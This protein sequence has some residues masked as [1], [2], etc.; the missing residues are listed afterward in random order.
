MSHGY[1]VPNVSPRS[2]ASPFRTR[3]TS[4]TPRFPSGDT[5]IGREAASPSTAAAR[6][7]VN[8]GERDRHGRRRMTKY[9]TFQNIPR[10]TGHSGKPVRTPTERR[11]ENIEYSLRL[12]NRPAWFDAL[13][14]SRP[15][16]VHPNRSWVHAYATNI[17]YRFSRQRG[18]EWKNC[19]LHFRL[20]SPCARPLPGQRLYLAI[21][22]LIYATDHTRM[23]F[24]YRLSIPRPVVGAVNRRGNKGI[25][26]RLLFRE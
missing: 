23:K 19:I 20:V 18:C 26:S 12:W 3:M 4:S 7:T 16:S 17:R 2:V 10:N 24:D 21:W 13:F 6:R 1:L 25:V 5:L 22:S 11:N 8:F 14:I 15:V 9:L